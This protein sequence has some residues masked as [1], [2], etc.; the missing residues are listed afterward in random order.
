MIQL[1]RAS[2]YA[3]RGMQYLAS[4]PGGS[5][6]MLSKISETQGVPSSFLGKIFQNLSRAN[7]VN[8]H[9]GA[10]GGFSLARPADEITLLEIIEATEGPLALYDC[11]ADEGA[12]SAFRNDCTI[13]LVLRDA[14]EALREVFG[15]STVADLACTRCATFAVHAHDGDTSLA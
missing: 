14:V 10:G 12:C 1:T 2:D 3:L 9:R 13:M 4:Q 8:S 7:I 6:C 11:I 5:V 15:K